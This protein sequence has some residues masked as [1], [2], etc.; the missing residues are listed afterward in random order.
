MGKHT[1][2]KLQT[3]V[4]R[5]TTNIQTVAP[6]KQAAGSAL[7]EKKTIPLTFQLRPK[8]LKNKM[9]IFFRNLGFKGALRGGEHAEGPPVI[10]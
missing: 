2:S 3:R 1:D 10:G 4:G 8:D 5:K 6:K 9:A 7:R